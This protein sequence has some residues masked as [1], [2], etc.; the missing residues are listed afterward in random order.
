[1]L[2]P[3]ELRQSKSKRATF[4]LWAVAMDR[5]IYLPS[6]VSLEDTINWD[7]IRP[8]THDFW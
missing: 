4:L 8:V 3:E 7:S 5:L 6:D 2:L 1:M